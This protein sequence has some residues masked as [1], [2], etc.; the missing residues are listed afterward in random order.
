M[1]RTALSNLMMNKVD[2]FF[3]CVLAI[4]DDAGNTWEIT[5]NRKGIF[6][7]AR[8]E[9][10]RPVENVA[11]VLKKIWDSG[12]GLIELSSKTALL[13]H[14][15]VPPNGD[16]KAHEYSDAQQK[17][18][19][20]DFYT[21]VAKGTERHRLELGPLLGQPNFT[22]AQ[23]ATLAEE[24]IAID[25]GLRALATLSS[26][27]QPTKDATAIGVEI[28]GLETQLHHL[29]ELNLDLRL[30][31]HL[32]SHLPSEQKIRSLEEKIAKTR[33]LNRADTGAL[34]DWDQLAK[35][36]SQIEVLKLFNGVAD[37]LIRSNTEQV[38]V[39]YHEYLGK[40]QKILSKDQRL[41][42]TLQSALDRSALPAVTANTGESL[43]SRVKAFLLPH[44]G[45]E[46]VAIQPV[47]DLTDRLREVLEVVHRSD[48]YLEDRK[49][50]LERSREVLESFFEGNVQKLLQLKRKWQTLAKTNG[51][52]DDLR[53]ASLIS[54]IVDHIDLIRARKELEWINPLM[55]EYQ[56]V[57]HRIK[58]SVAEW[59]RMRSE[60]VERN[61]AELL[62]EA[63]A[64]VAMMPTLLERLKLQ[65]KVFAKTVQLPSDFRGEI[66]AK[67]QQLETQWDQAFKKRTL[68]VQAQGIDLIKKCNE[69]MAFYRLEQQLLASSRRLFQSAQTAISTW[70]IPRGL[71]REER[72]QLVSTI[73]ELAP[74]RIHLILT[75]D[76]L[77]FGAL[78]KTSL[79]IAQR[80]QPEVPQ[81][82]AGSP[83][84]TPLLSMNQTD[85]TSPR[86]TKKVEAN[87]DA[88]T[89]AL[90]AML[91]GGRK[92]AAVES[93]D[94]RKK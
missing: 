45:R 7:S 48:E 34:P 47:D 50:S 54:I 69:F 52:P 22:S 3:H 88:K 57:I 44:L 68:N 42:A 51:L 18:S 29:K 17:I 90:V 10:P 49:S 2:E 58:S 4:I 92:I 77:V 74:S 32:E 60:S 84:P 91:N 21:T 86:E 27:A 16:L 55:A 89:K 13:K 5:A 70:Q 82:I 26:S 28:Q 66:E 61:E 72:V 71:S 39:F 80:V 25:S 14:F 35:L 62:S 94:L 46:V 19:N 12:T 83:K 59:H 11:S 8:G 78:R 23:M 56:K 1:L 6:C 81:V 73:D 41:I 20:D 43:F 31:R 9:P 64:I 15:I 67:R 93:N 38:R 85:T 37:K 75:N 65:K 63:E 33:L 87:L 79:G 24:L 36:L 53:V 40:L 30:L 76:E